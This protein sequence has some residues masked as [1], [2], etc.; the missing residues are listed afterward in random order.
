MLVATSTNASTGNA[1]LANTTNGVMNGI[2]AMAAAQDNPYYNCGLVMNTAWGE[3]ARDPCSMDV[4]TASDKM[5]AAVPKCSELR[6]GDKYK[7]SYRALKHDQDTWCGGPVC[8]PTCKA[9]VTCERE[10][11]FPFSP[12]CQGATMAD[13]VAETT[14][15]APEWELDLEFGN[16]SA[17]VALAVTLVII[18]VLL[19]AYAVTHK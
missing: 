14:T 12:E 19:A 15:T 8:N 6:Q 13:I 4:W 18:S 10:G 2:V 9:G 1:T 5:K 16:M 17:D 7:E 11:D 3:M